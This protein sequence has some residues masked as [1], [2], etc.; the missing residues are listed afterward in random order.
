V[1]AFCRREGI[2]ESA[3]F[4][5]RRELASR[6]EK[7]PTSRP[8]ASDP[9][10]AASERRPQSVITPRFLPLQV[11]SEEAT[12]RVGGVEIQLG[13]GRL[14][15]VR[16]GFDRRTLADVLAVLEGRPC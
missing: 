1:R 2:K 4:W 7:P 16:P 12:D 3:F 14:I 6:R 10:P 5:W 11:V 9:S 15:R 13:E 8:P